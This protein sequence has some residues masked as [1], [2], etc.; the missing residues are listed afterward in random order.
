VP[1]TVL[2][3]EDVGW[4]KYV[5]RDS[6]RCGPPRITFDV[7]HLLI[8]FAPYQIKSGATF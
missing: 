1:V 7:I 4:Y 5:A 6:L 2:M 8:G 3:Q